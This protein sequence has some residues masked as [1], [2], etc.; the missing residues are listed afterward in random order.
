[1]PWCRSSQRTDRLVCDRSVSGILK[2]VLE[3]IA[4]VNILSGNSSDKFSGLRN[5]R[6]RRSKQGRHQDG[7]NSN[8][9]SHLGSPIVCLSEEIA[10][11]AVR[12]A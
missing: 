6:H 8:M 7:R 2:S 10:E 9:R 12:L 1:M 5:D 3:R 11:S 4:P